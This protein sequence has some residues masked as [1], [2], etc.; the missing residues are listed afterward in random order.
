MKQ[1]IFICALAA[2]LLAPVANADR[3][4][5]KGY[6]LYRMDTNDDGQITLDEF[7]SRG[8]RSGGASHRA[9]LDDDGNVTIDE[10]NAH[11]DLRKAQ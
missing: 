11:L 3:E 1:P 10:L 2:L 6:I 7:H 9:D 8:Y 4:G 5:R